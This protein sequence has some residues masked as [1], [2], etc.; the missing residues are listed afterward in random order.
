MQNLQGKSKL[1]KGISQ[2]LDSDGQLG[3]DFSLKCE[4]HG[5]VTKVRY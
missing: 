5:V 2:I 1:W 3:P 4:V